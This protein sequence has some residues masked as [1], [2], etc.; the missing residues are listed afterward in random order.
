MLAFKIDSEEHFKMP[1]EC[2]F[3][4]IQAQIHGCLLICSEFILTPFYVT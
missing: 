1:K 3:E 2:I 4:E